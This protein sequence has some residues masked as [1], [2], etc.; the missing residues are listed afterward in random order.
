MDS[1]R[2]RRMIR[3]LLGCSF[4][5]ASVAGGTA[6]AAAAAAAPAPLQIDLDAFD[7]SKKSV[8]LPN[9]ESLAYVDRGNPRV[10][11]WC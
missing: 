4:L 1:S 3:T 9:G 11:W 6:I 5:I 10:P 7:A 2:L 8:A